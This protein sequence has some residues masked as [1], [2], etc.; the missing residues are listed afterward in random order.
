MNATPRRQRFVWTALFLALL[1]AVPASAGR[2]Y[3]QYT[4]PP[5]EL[6]EVVVTFRD[7]AVFQSIADVVNATLNLPR[8][9]PVIFDTCGE[10][11]ALFR[12]DAKDIIMCYEMVGYMVDL[13]ANE[14][15]ATEEEIGEAIIGSLGFFL[16]HEMGHALVNVLDL[17]ITG[18]EEDA[19]D[20]LASL[21]LLAGDGHDLLL[22]AADSFEAFSAGLS[23]NTA[24][25]PFWD[26]HSLSPQ[27]SFTIACL[28][29]GSEP[30]AY[31]ALVGPNMLPA[32]RAVR[33]ESD[34]HQKWRAWDRLLTP[35]SP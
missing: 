24:E 9:V 5:P 25:L 17:P 30:Q 23:G 8:D 11:N 33:C 28:V 18:K 31:A 7:E 1:V 34:F 22:A 4:Q 21:I 3:V 15:G 10:P 35:Y 26:E 29:Y 19:V 14:P 2:F 32:E 12:P 16:L 13:F 20:D 27:R 6:E